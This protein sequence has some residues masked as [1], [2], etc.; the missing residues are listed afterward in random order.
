MVPPDP[1]PWGYGEKGEQLAEW[2]VREGIALQNPRSHP[3]P[4]VE[5][6]GESACSRA[7]ILSIASNVEGGPNEGLAEG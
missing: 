2:G 1:A 3:S 4:D 6:R 5:R 7:W